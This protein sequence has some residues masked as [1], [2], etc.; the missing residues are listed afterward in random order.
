MQTREPSTEVVTLAPLEPQPVIVRRTSA[1]A[2]EHEPE[3]DTYLLV[4]AAGCYWAELH[5]S[6]DGECVGFGCHTVVKSRDY[7][8]TDY[9]HR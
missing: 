3:S 4:D 7:V 9:A 1:W 5:R 8:F 6:D 2:I